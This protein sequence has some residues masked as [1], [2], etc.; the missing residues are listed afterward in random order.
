MDKKNSTTNSSDI[1]GRTYETS[2][3][4]KNDVVATGL[5]TTHEQA[6]DS[7]MEGAIDPSTDDDL[8]AKDLPIAQKP[9]R[10]E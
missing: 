2:D 4:Q 1:A 10:N 7:Y 6:S 3:Y 5:S 9:F 8:N